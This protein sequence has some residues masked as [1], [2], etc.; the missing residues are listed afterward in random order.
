MPERRSPYRPRD[1]QAAPGSQCPTSA[2][3]QAAVGER[4]R[5]DTN[6]SMSAE[7]G[8][9]PSI[10]SVVVEGPRPVPSRDVR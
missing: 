4:D 3:R 10:A 5:A 2:T 8:Q 9:P 1:I 7:R 6:P